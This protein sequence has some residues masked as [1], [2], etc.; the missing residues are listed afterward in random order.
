MNCS[1]Q[2]KLLHWEGRN[3]NSWDCST[4]VPLVG[5]GNLGGKNSKENRKNRL[6]TVLNTQG[7]EG[8]SQLPHI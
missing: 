8:S 4:F 5:K 1:L 7:Q 3:A 2:G 6:A